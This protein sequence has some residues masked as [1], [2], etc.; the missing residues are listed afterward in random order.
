MNSIKARST[1]FLRCVWQLLV[2]P[3]DSGERVL[4]AIVIGTLLGIG[5]VYP[6]LWWVGIVGIPIFMELVRRAPSKRAAV[7]SGW[8]ALA[9]SHAWSLS[10]FW[11]V[12]PIE[13]LPVGGIY[14]QVLLVGIYWSTAALWLGVGG[15]VIGLVWWYVARHWPRTWW[16]VT[17]GLWVAGE[18]F[19]SWFFALLTWQTAIDIAPHFSFGYRGYLLAHHEWLF[20]IASVAG[21][22]GLS[23]V[24]VWLG[25]SSYYLLQSDR[26]Y[27]VAIFAL[28]LTVSYW[29]PL[30]TLHTGSGANVSV[31]VIE[32]AFTGS[33]RQTTAID[34]VLDDAI[35]IAEQAGVAYVILPEDMRYLTSRL[36]DPFLPLQLRSNFGTSSFRI[37]D[38]G[39]VATEAGAV[40][41][42]VIYENA[43]A[44]HW[45]ADKQ[46][47]V[48]Q[49]EFLPALYVSALQV[50]GYGPVLQEISRE[51]NYVPGPYE[52]QQFSGDVPGLLFCFEGV[53]PWGV[54]RILA[55][56]DTKPQFVA[57][58]ISHAWFH[59]PTTLWQ[60]LD[61]MLR[62]Q[63]R[64]NRVP[65]VSAGNLAPSVVYYPS[66]KI[67]NAPVREVSVSERVQIKF[68]TISH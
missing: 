17:P 35:A 12:L 38:S 28:A 46:Y 14:I 53:T 45:V 31:A 29:I 68:Y 26:R 65:I 44:E 27:V 32:T 11:S 62:V 10:W 49:G 8:L 15:A 48:P 67:D 30:P 40:L 9:V 56:R 54:R 13:W 34:T 58:P 33:Y 36:N 41:R 61:I 6:G 55:E 7:W 16:Y 37:I 50:V 63:A 4:G 19:G 42:G 18:V 43:T 20:T 66:G 60:Q 64:W 57:H 25:Y 52:K 22:Y 23:L 5:F 1:N 3:H 39:R 59:T 51:V 24:A 2:R 47:L 21:V